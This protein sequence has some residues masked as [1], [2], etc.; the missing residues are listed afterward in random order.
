MANGTPT[1][2]V[3]PTFPEKFQLT[4]STGS[5]APRIIEEYDDG[6]WREY[7]KA[8]G[9]PLRYMTCM[10]ASLPEA[11]MQAVVNFF[12]T[13]TA[14]GDPNGGVF[15]FTDF[16]DLTTIL[17]GKFLDQRIDFQIDGQC[18]WSLVNALSI[19]IVP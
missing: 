18:R 6:N 2:L 10:L 12:E 11:R 3:L 19:K 9:T 4:S 5:A 14:P 16:R 13:V 7:R 8:G 1:P 15:Q 17:H